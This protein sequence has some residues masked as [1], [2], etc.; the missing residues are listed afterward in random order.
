MNSK[1]L[2]TEIQNFIAENLNTNITSLLLKG[3]PFDYIP[4]QDVIKQIEAKN[5]CKNK[6]PTWFNTENIYYPNKLN[7]EQTSSEVTAKY[8]S[9]LISGARIIDLTGGFGVDCYYFSKRFEEVIHCDINPKLSDIV[10]NNF[11]A[12]GVKNCQTFAGDGLEYLKGTDKTFDWIYI[13][14]SR[15]HDSKGKV[16]FLNDCLPNVPEHLNLLFKHSKNI[17]IKTSPLL[18]FS[19]G[20]SELKHVKNIIVVSVNNE[21]KELL[22]I[23]EAGFKEDIAI[24]TVNIKKHETES[25]SFY[26]NEEKTAH[27]TYSDPLTYLYEPNSSILKSGAFQS[28][29]EKL[30]LDKLHPNAH[31]YTNEALI[32]FPGRRFKIDD[33]IPYNKKA[34][35][36]LANTKANITTRNFPESVQQIRKK[37]K[38]KDGGDRYLFFTS[39]FDNDKLVLVCSKV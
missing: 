19:V 29:S 38:I 35:K 10:S 6:L 16:F 1:I 18:D 2:N 5:R 4:P 34:L 36:H 3:L 8:K 39:N 24:K 30:Q 17:L 20:I 21:V 28:I 27:A 15:R 11:K 32:D 22:W 9:E 25:F 26:L 37:F 23:L 33:C 12:L 7:I 14:P 31:L 13:D